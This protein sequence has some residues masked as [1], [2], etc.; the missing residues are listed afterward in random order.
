M[1]LCIDL[2]FSLPINSFC[3]VLGWQNNKESVDDISA[4]LAGISTE[5]DISIFYCG[6]D[7]GTKHSLVSVVWLQRPFLFSQL[8]NGDLMLLLV[9]DFLSMQ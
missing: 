3:I 9:S 8:S 6:V 5:I 1:R 7:Q 4:T 2:D